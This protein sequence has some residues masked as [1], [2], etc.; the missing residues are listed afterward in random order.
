MHLDWFYTPGLLFW[1]SSLLTFFFLTSQ[2]RWVPSVKYK[3]WQSGGIRGS[4]WIFF[5]NCAY[6]CSPLFSGP[7]LMGKVFELLL[8]ACRD[9][10]WLVMAMVLGLTSKIPRL[11]RNIESNREILS[12]KTIVFHIFNMLEEAVDFYF[13]HRWSL[14]FGIH[15]P[16]PRAVAG[17]RATQDWDA[18]DG[19]TMPQPISADLS[20]SL[21]C[22]RYRQVQG[23]RIGLQKGLFLSHRKEMLHSAPCPVSTLKTRAGRQESWQSPLT[24]FWC[25]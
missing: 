4:L 5:W 1:S 8:I 13:G 3:Q 18:W 11:K 12:G 24:P 23:D 7:L 21:G 2:V 9:L 22:D 25:I 17:A 16:R 6:H 15:R 20:R 14:R 19:T 10:S